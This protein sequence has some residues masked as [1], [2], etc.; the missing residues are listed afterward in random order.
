MNFTVACSG[1]CGV[2]MQA[3][4]EAGD[5]MGNP[6]DAAQD[7]ST[8]STDASDSSCFCCPPSFCGVGI[9]AFSD[10]GDGD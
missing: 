9:A 6:T 8:A 10:A 3:F 4:T 1:F 2:A 5:A 7:A